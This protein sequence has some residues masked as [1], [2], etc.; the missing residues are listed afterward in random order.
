MPAG[1][2]RDRRIDKVGIYRRGRERRT[3]VRRE[4]ALRVPFARGICSEH[5][6]TLT[7][8]TPCSHE[9]HT[10]IQNQSD[11]AVAGTRRELTCPRV[12]S[13]C[14]QPSPTLAAARSHVVGPAAGTTPWLLHKSVTKQSWLCLNCD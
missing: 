4:C 1:A 3:V 2:Q 12:R 10:P 5:K 14:A 8:M 7:T 6:I 13:R 9:L 11:L